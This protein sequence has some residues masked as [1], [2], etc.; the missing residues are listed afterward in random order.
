MEEAPISLAKSNA[1]TAAKA[2][3]SS[4]DCGRV[5]LF[6]IETITSPLINQLH[7]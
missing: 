7:T 6:D 1:L 2:S 4:T 3:I 5:D